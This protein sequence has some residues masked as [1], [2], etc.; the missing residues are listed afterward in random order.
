MTLAEKSIFIQNHEFILTNGRAMFWPKKKALIFSDLHLGKTAHFRK[1]GIALPSSLILEDLNRLSGLIHHF[2]A[3]KLMVVGDFLHAGKNSEF[4]IFKEWKSEFSHIEIMLIKG[5]HD[6]IPEAELS[7]LGLTEIHSTWEESG[8]VFSHDLI[9]TDQFL[10]SGHIH[11]GLSLKTGT[12]RYLKFPC[13]VVCEK[14]LILPAFSSFT[15]LDTINHPEN[16]TYFFFSEE[17]IYQ[18]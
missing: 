15:G 9:K 12:R 17:G 8:F 14:Q 18:L 11:P 16:A 5:N 3:E 13:Y 10:I 6:R 2:Q 1:N 4:E 7:K